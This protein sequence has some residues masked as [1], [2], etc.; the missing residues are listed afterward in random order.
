MSWV[1]VRRN[2]PSAIVN[3]ILLSI[4]TQ[5][6]RN[7]RMLSVLRI[8]LDPVVMREAGL[9]P[10]ISVELLRGEAE[11]SGKI[12]L[13]SAGDRE[14]F[15]IAGQQARKN[16]SGQIVL[17]ASLLGLDV[18][19]GLPPTRTKYRI[20]PEFLEIELPRRLFSDTDPS[21]PSQRPPEPT[22][23][24][25]APRKGPP[26][27]HAAKSSLGSLI[28]AANDSR[29]FTVDRF[30]ELQNGLL[31]KGT[32]VQRQPAGPSSL[33]C[34]VPELVPMIHTL[35]GGSGVCRG[36]VHRFFSYRLPW[37]PA[38]LQ[39]LAF[40]RSTTY[41]RHRR[42]TSARGIGSASSSSGWTRSRTSI[43]SATPVPYRC[44]YWVQF[45]RVA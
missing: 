21:S 16:P 15:R 10:G 26:V 19:S 9:R 39:G 11:D 24:A 2:K 30:P 31:T 12:R 41:P 8:K 44:P 20:E 40:D 13:C 32:A 5:K 28:L 34:A 27:R 7:G 36:G 45:R 4:T 18:P 22:G 25:G 6:L 14:G 35:I 29:Q 17:D 3:G 23:Y 33:P 1:A 38:G 37:P 43:P 42:T